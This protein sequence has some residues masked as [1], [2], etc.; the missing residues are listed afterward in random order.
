MGRI[1]KYGDS[2]VINSKPSSCPTYSAYGDSDYMDACLETTLR[3]DNPGLGWGKNRSRDQSR[4]S[5]DRGEYAHGYSSQG[6]YNTTF[7]SK[8]SPCKYNSYGVPNY[9]SGPNCPGPK[10]MMGGCSQESCSGN[11]C[12]MKTPGCSCEGGYC[13]CGP[14]ASCKGIPYSCRVRRG[15]GR[16]GNYGRPGNY[17]VDM[18]LYNCGID[19]NC[20]RKYMYGE[21]KS[22]KPCSGIATR[23][24]DPYFY[25]EIEDQ[26]VRP[27]E[28]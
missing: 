17:I 5:E 4:I 11:Y 13:G 15:A 16:V 25:V 12:T 22:N 27:T 24:F 23:E 28:F 21:P 1:E 6:L 18:S 19:H 26:L 2:I 7:E 14:G 3:R 9:K 8:M 10:C 20:S